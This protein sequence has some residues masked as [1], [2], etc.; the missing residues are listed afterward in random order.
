MTREIR[1]LAPT[2][3]R[4]FESGLARTMSG[5]TLATVLKSLAVIASDA[6]VLRYFGPGSYGEIAVALSVFSMLFMARLQLGLA[7]QTYLPRLHAK[8]ARQAARELL[9]RAYLLSCGCAAILALA[10]LTF[11][12]IIEV[13]Y[14]DRDLGLRVQLVA[15]A[16][17]T[18]TVLV[19]PMEFAALMALGRAKRLVALSLLESA[20]LVVASVLVVYAGLGISD[21][22]VISRLAPAVAA[23]ACWHWFIRERKVSDDFPPRAYESLSFLKLIQFSSQG[24]LN[25]FLAQVGRQAPIL[26]AGHLLAAAPLGILAFANSTVSRIW[27]TLSAPES[28]LLPHLAKGHTST[29]HEYIR[30]LTA[31]WLLLG[32]LGSAAAFATAVLALPIT[33]ILAGPEFSEASPLIAL[34]AL[35]LAFAGWEV[36]RF[37]LYIIG[38]MQSLTTLL[39]A[40]NLL[41]ALACWVLVQAYGS[42]GLAIASVTSAWIFSSLLVARCWRLQAPHT[43]SMYPTLPFQLLLSHLLVVPAGVAALLHFL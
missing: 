30:S 17:A 7:V 27:G 13:I 41:E 4:I 14:P 5:A 9:R 25:Q 33:A 32:T 40:R 12:P 23:P 35:R 38:Q 20:G 21:Y 10:S 34:Y 43:G 22:L 36:L 3:A 8:G 2:I 15:I 18:A 26:I 16:S 37:N 24:T 29:T 19:G 42:V 31:A 39:V 28:A 11:S 6:I 1:S